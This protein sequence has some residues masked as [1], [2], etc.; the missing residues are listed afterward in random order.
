MTA[1]SVTL[2]PFLRRWL[3]RVAVVAAIV[4]LAL[5]V[6][7]L[8]LHLTTDPL[9]DTRL[10]Y[11]AATRLNTGQPL[12]GAPPQ[13]NVGPYAG[14]P[15]LAVLF[16]PLA[17]LPFPAAAVIWQ[18]VLMLSFLGILVRAGLRRPV[19]L[20]VGCLALPIFWAISIGQAEIIVTFL[21]AIATPASVALAGHLK[22]LPWLAAIYWLGRGD[23]RALGRFVA[24]AL[25]LG[26]L[27]LVLEPAGT[28]AYIR[29]EWLKTAFAYRNVSLFAVHPVLWAVAAAVAVVVAYRLAPTRYGWAAAVCLV[30]VASPRLLVYQAMTLLAAFSRPADEP[31][32]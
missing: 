19:L 27:Q 1:S 10:Y 31:R 12:Y 3:G 28:L 6:Q 30:V 7:A 26:V 5:G 18:A 21:L 20:A 17:L 4:G 16:R 25:G 2:S 24:W 11:D 15:L 32:T 23:R 14:P 9:A 22:L 13:A 8:I 29:L